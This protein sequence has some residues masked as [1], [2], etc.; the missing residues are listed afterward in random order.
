MNIAALFSLTDR[1][2]L[3]TGASSGIGRTI[4][5]ALAEAGASIVLVARRDAELGEARDA[6]ITQGGRAEALPCDLAD[7]DGIDACAAAATRFF[8]APDIVV[9][10]A[11]VN[12]RK[13][14][15][16]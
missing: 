6:I 9:N 7:R 12:I 16:D 10:S 13:P 4:A 3:V 11:G 5:Q 15:L 1:V 8:G 14:M 2:A